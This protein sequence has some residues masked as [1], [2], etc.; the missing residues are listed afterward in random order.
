MKLI[1]LNINGIF[2]LC[3]LYKVKTL[4]VFGSILTDRF[5][6]SSDVDFAFTFHPD[7]THLTYFDNFYGLYEGLKKLLNRDVDLVDE[8]SLKNQYFKE[9]LEETKH[10]IYG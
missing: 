3:K 9:E 10:L 5:N 4:A 6:D 2:E 7:V 8:T 1:E